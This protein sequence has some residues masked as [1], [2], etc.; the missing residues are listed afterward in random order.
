MHLNDKK[1]GSTCGYCKNAKE[2]PGGATW[3]VGL[4]R[5]STDDYQKLMDAGWQRCGTYFYKFDLEKSCCPAYIIRLD[6]NDFKITKSQKSVLK[7]FNKYLIHG[8]SDKMDANEEEVMKPGDD[9]D[10]KKDNTVKIQKL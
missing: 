6:V 7:K 1:T 4:P 2:N 9:E 10:Q 3:G 8:K 5:L